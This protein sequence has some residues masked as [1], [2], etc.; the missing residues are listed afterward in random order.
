MNARV[1]R[2]FLIKKDWTMQTYLIAAYIIAWLGICI[3][4]V[5][6]SMRMRGV[7]TE[8]AAVEELLHE[9]QEQKEL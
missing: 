2:R 3:Y 1:L 9:Q 8:L 7:R 5:M 4:L 6:L